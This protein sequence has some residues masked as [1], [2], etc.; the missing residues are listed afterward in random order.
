[1]FYW[2]GTHTLEATTGADPTFTR[3]TAATV[4]DFEGLIKTVE[5]SEPRFQGARR[6]ENV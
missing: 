6:V 2:P 3:T 4:K 1:M 5:T